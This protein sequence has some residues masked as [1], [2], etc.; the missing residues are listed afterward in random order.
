MARKILWSVLAVVLLAMVVLVGGG[1]YFSGEISK[2]TLKVD[3][4]KRLPDLE[5]VE[6]SAD[7]VTLRTT[8]DTKSIDWQTE[9]VW[10]I[11]CEDGYGQVGEIIDLKGQT[12]VRKYIPLDGGLEI[13]DRV[14]VDSCAFPGDPLQAHGIAFEEVY[15]SSTLGSFPAWYV[16][17]SGNVWAIFVHGRGA[18][19]RAALPVL[20]VLKELDLPSLVITY[21]NDEGVPPDPRGLYRLGATEWMDLEGAV[22]YA[23]ENG[24][25]GIILIGHSMGGATVMEFLYESPLAEKVKGV[26]LDSPLLDFGAAVDHGASQRKMPLIGTPIPGPIVWMAKNLSSVRFG[27]DYSELDY[28][29]RTDELATPILLFQGDSDKTVPVSCADMLA[30][31]RPDIVRYIRISGVDHVDTWNM[32]RGEY[33]AA[34]KDFLLD[35]V[36]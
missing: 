13:G 33:E 26:V 32:Q 17:G 6:L 35:V 34:M 10:G 18:S 36:Q 20:P 19:R 12:V 27:L 14:R 31:K 30:E 11:E 4:S 2:A 16:E 29:S 1:W 21:R 8:A 3:H 9:G 22:K 5:V 25:E 7:R 15:F 23:S 28:L 24:A